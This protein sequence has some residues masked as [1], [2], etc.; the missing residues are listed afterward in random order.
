M[1]NKI[2]INKETIDFDN[3]SSLNSYQQEKEKQI[4]IINK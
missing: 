1:N 3:F 2:S 4:S